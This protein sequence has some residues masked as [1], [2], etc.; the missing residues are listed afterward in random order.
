MPWT[1]LQ[2]TRLAKDSDIEVEPRMKEE[3]KSDGQEFRFCHL[4]GG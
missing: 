4:T 1:D 3:K 2:L